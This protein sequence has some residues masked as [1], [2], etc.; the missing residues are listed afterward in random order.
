M[1]NNNNPYIHGINCYNSGDY[2]N[3]RKWLVIASGNPLYEE[4]AINM[5]AII[6]IS[7]SNYLKARSIL[8]E[9]RDILYPNHAENYGI[10]EM[11][12]YN[13]NKSKE[14]IIDSFNNP[15]FQPN[16]LI[17]LADLYVELG[18]YDIA[19]KMYET[20]LNKSDYYVKATLKLIY[21]SIIEKNYSYASRLFKNINEYEVSKNLYTRLSIT[22]DYFNKKLK[23]SKYPQYYV[24]RLL[25]NDD[26]DL[27][28]H[29]KRHVGE[30]N[31]SDGSY[32]FPDINLEKTILEVRKLIG[33]LNP[34]YD[35]DSYEYKISFQSPVG[36]NGGE[37]TNSLK[38][39]TAI[40]T[41][42]IITMYPI[43]LSNEFNQEGYMENKQL[44]LKRKRGK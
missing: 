43:L 39:I 27:M 9:N 22:L 30:N 31:A 44:L 42:R 26:N 4:K 6:E 29:V 5:L 37:I 34:K 10:L 2:V 12:E 3:A 35:E 20:L 23:L 17:Y 15:D 1:N 7:C 41:N 8:E 21:L 38:A 18:E 11:K 32:F 24:R 25:R 13:Y 40:G 16:K 33:E 36:Y 19:R 28:E 14:N